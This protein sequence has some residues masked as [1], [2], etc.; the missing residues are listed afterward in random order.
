MSG[1]PSP[2]KSPT[3]SPQNLG[4]IGR[5][6]VRQFSRR[7]PAHRPEPFSPAFIRMSGGSEKVFATTTSFQPSP[8]RS[9]ISTARES[10][11]RR[12]SGARV[13]VM[14]VITPLSLMNRT[15]GIGPATVKGN[16]RTTITS[17]S[18]SLSMSPTATSFSCGSAMP[19]PGAETSRVAVW[20]ENWTQ[21]GTAWAAAA[22][23]RREDAPREGG[24]TRAGMRGGRGTGSSGHSSFGTDGPGG[25]GGGTPMFRPNRPSVNGIGRGDRVSPPDASVPFAPAGSPE[26]GR[27]SD[28]GL[29]LEPGRE[30]DPARH[31]QRTHRVEDR[32]LL[33]ERRPP[34]PHHHRPGRRPGPRP[35]R[36]PDNPPRETGR[37]E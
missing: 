24:G 29:D 2:L 14:S 23:E 28:A 10:E 3:P 27:A 15:L 30:R 34:N 11:G 22:G 5:G 16:F 26:G 32:P 18:P 20:S 33:V 25:P 8:S 17:S 36:P 19:T 1:I 12:K 21:T 13:A 35:N 31:R 37:R 6:G 4:G 9:T 7:M